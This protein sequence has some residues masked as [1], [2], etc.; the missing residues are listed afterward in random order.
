VI[1]RSPFLQVKR[2]KRGWRDFTYDMPMGAS[3]AVHARFWRSGRGCLIGDGWRGLA[4]CLASLRY[5][6]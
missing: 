1:L 5:S 4:H 2:A 3:R 6:S